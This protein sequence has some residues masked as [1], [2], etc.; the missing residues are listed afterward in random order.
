MQMVRTIF[1]I[2]FLLIQSVGTLLAQDR[3]NRGKEFWLGYGHN[4]MFNPTAGNNSQ[5]L[6]LYIS[7]V[8]PATVVVSIPGNGWSQSVVI[9]ANSVDASVV[10]P[11][12]GLQDARLTGEGIFNRGIHVKADVP[13]VLNAHQYGLNS[14]GAMMVMP[15]ETYGYNYYSVN[16]KQVSNV[17]YSHSWFYVVAP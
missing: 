2:L 16:C 8:L 11:K 12:T 15:S 1:M 9:P 10:I 3:S 14:S 17:D 6:V 5:T 13:V 4:V 7:T